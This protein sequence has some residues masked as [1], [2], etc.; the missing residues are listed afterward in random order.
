MYVESSPAPP[1]RLGRDATP[2]TTD[3]GRPDTDTSRR[4]R[5]A[6]DAIV[7][8]WLLELLPADRR[9]AVKRA[10]PA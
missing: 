1:R 10:S 7:S 3:A 8:R 9:R 2:E 5:V 4:A 6:E